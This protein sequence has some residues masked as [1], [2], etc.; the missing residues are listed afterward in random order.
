MIVS[1]TLI[2]YAVIAVVSYLLGSLNF[3]V[4]LSK[5][6]KKDDVRSHGSGNA[7]TTNMLRSYGKGIAVLTIIGDMAKVAVAI[8]AAYLIRNSLS[9]QAFE[10]LA[11]ESGFDFEVVFKMYAGLFCVIGHIFPCFFSFKGGK[12]VATSGGMVFMIDWKIALILLAMFIV[13]V[14]ITK[15]VSLGSLVMAFF[16]PIFIFI[17]YK[18]LIPTAIAVVFAVIVF[19]AH[20]QNIVKLCKGTEN[21]IG[22]KNKSGD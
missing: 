1:A 20:R 4:I 8:G 2:A 7:G 3:G 15:Y 9:P 17:F 19:V 14:L 18:S 6:F 22:N 16:Y 5:R 11:N 13:V 12:G 10:Y 21:K